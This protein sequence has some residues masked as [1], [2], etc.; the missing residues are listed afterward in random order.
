MIGI[1]K[2]QKAL[3]IRFTNN[4]SCADKLM[5][6]MIHEV[7]RNF[8]SDKTPT[9]IKQDTT[10][11]LFKIDLEKRWGFT[12]MGEREGLSKDWYWS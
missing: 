9:K 1:F 5:A 8:F 6:S 10:F 2:D 4:L 3:A 11:Y 12:Y 7:R